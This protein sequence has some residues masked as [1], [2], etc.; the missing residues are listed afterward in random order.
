MTDIMVGSA[1]F[2]SRNFHNNEQT[3][4]QRSRKEASSS[5]PDK[6]GYI[7]NN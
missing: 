5:N 7:V 3:E 2:L 6:E 1:R 4:R